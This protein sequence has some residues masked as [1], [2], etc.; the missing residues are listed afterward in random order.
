MRLGGWSRLWIVVSVLYLIGLVVFVTI[1]LPRPEGIPHSPSFYAQMTPD[2]RG[3]M[4][5][6][7]S[8]GIDAPDRQALIDE[9]RRRG[10]IT[11]VE[12]PNRH[13]LVFDSEVPR[14]EQEAVAKAYWKTVE[15]AAN[16]ERWKYVGLAFLWWVIPVL[17][18]YA[19]GWSVG[20]VY[21]GFRHQ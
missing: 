8:S 4:L 5:G 17:A 6:T 21:P 19:L 12:M 13:T 18:V 16:E 10:V 1:T 2:L 3:K 9:A 15:G 14:N 11:E 20:W 7:R